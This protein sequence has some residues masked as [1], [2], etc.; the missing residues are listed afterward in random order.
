MAI[1]RNFPISKADAIGAIRWPEVARRFSPCLGLPLLTSRGLKHR[2]TLLPPPVVAFSVVCLLLFGLC[3]RA[4]AAPSTTQTVPLFAGW[5]LV[6]IQ[7][8]EAPLPVASFKAA[9]ADPARLIEVWGY[10]G[11]GDPAALGAWKTYQPTIASYPSDLTQIAPGRGYWVNVAQSTTLTLTG[12]AWSGTL[13]LGAG[14]NLV[15][16]SVLSLGANEAQDL[17]SVFGSTFERVT[18]VWSF[19]ASTQRFAGYDLTAIPAVKTMSNIAPGAG[20]WVYALQPVTLAPQ[21]YVALPADGDVAPLQTT[22]LFSSSDP[23]WLGANPTKYVGKQVRYRGATDAAQ[24]LNGNGLL[25]EATTQDTVLFEVAS[26]AIPVT[27]GNSGTGALS[28]VLENNVPWLYTAPADPRTW[29]TGATTRPKTAGGVVSTDKDTLILYADRTGMTPG[30]KSGSAVTLWVGGTA[31][32]INLLIDVPEVDGDWRGFATTT[33][34]GGKDISLGEVRLAL[35]MFR[36]DALGSPTSFRAVLNREQA[37]LFPRDV[38]MDGIFFNGEQFKLTTNFSMPAGDRNAPPYN[39]FSNPSPNNPNY[40][41]PKWRAKQDKDLN[42]DGKVDVMNPFPF[43]LRREITLIGRRITPN[44]LEGSYVEAIRGMLPPV[45][46]NTLSTVDAQFLSDEFLTTSQPIFIEGTFVLERQTFT[47]SQRSAFNQ[48]VEPQVSIGGT[49]SGSRTEFQ[50]VSAKATVSGLSVTLALDLGKI[51][52]ALLRISLLSPAG[53]SFVLHDY[54]AILAGK[55]ALPPGTFAG[56]SAQGTWQLALEWADTAG[57]RGTLKSWSLNIEGSSTHVATGKL[58]RQGTSAAVPGIT[59]RLEGGVTSISAVS[60]AAG[61]F[62]FPQ[63]TENDYTLVINAPGYQA[64]TV[65]FFIGEQ[66]VTLPDIALVP[67]TVTQPTIKAAPVLG[68]EPLNVDFQM[69]VPLTQVPA[70]VTWNF[71]DGT[72]PVSGPFSGALI[73][74][75]HTYASAGHFTPIVTLS[76]G[77]LGSPVVVANPPIIHVERRVP[78]GGTGAPTQQVIAGIF[79]GSVAGRMDVGA[80][81]PSAAP[82]ATA[83]AQTTF[84]A[85]AVTVNMA[86][87]TV[88]QESQSDSATFDVDRFPFGTTN[89]AVSSGQ[90]DTDFGRAGAINAGG[91]VFVFYNT[92]AVDNAATATDERWQTRGWGTTPQAA[93]PPSVLPSLPSGPL[94]QS[95]GTFETYVPT[96]PSRP[97]RFRMRVTLGGS[98]LAAEAAPMGDVLL[99]PGRTLK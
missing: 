22:Q 77:S 93:P 55:Y 20:Y 6:S 97:E 79:M 30:R 82:F 50:T 39:T 84:A 52:P 47:P 86:S 92:S 45:S 8:G 16:F 17:V 63:L 21:S 62:R 25:D 24:D 90:E 31:Y 88:Y 53:S 68:Y 69:L 61:G 94:Y 38:Y 48:T 43:G 23:R 72:T 9:L 74:P 59:V 78:Q 28:W 96:T 54:A 65:V 15:G 57:E 4:S 98:V 46:G 26:E 37:I 83:D 58:V 3:A 19:D 60:D 5:N 10:E 81:V 76:G 32:P 44:R 80:G 73:A 12:P 67:E 7:V 91:Q 89:W 51:D 85:G 66:D 33:R 35:N 41:D 1:R 34:V 14:W 71:G 42:G 95:A 49:G 64:A 70:Q 87:A 75:S 56:E 13:T 27:I 40:N 99:F 18:Q 2:A 29:P 36:P 11:S